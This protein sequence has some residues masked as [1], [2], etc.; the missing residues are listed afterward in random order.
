MLSVRGD[1]WLV[2]YI[3][4]ASKTCFNGYLTWKRRLFE[5]WQLKGIFSCFIS[6][7]HF[8]IVNIH[9]FVYKL[10]KPFIGWPSETLNFNPTTLNQ[11]SN[12]FL[13]RTSWFS[14]L[15]YESQ[16]LQTFPIFGLPL[17]GFSPESACEFL[18]RLKI[19]IRLHSRAQIVLFEL[20][21]VFLF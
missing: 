16:T 19:C 18:T 11:F 1:G 12:S 7:I 21:S 3:Y 15:K 10:T 6:S 8:I 17:F 2:L 9:S 20:N 14:I 13:D 5:R 4:L